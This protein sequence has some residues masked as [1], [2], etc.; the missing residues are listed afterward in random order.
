[1][2]LTN[3]L[4]M[5]SISFWIITGKFSQIKFLEVK[6]MRVFLRNIHGRNDWERRWVF[7]SVDRGGKR[8]TAVAEPSFFKSASKNQSYFRSKFRH[9][10]FICKSGTFEKFVDS[11]YS[12]GYSWRC[13]YRKCGKRLSP[14]TGSWFENSKLDYSEILQVTYCW[15]VGYPNWTASRELMWVNTQV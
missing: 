8:K 15:A 5:L 9:T 12:D 13:T 1:M 3:L 2:S 10:C 14:K 11:N 6:E 4:K 7:E